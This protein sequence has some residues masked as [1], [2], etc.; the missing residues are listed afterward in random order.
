MRQNEITIA[1]GDML[2]FSS[3]AIRHEPRRVCDQTE[4]VLRRNG[5]RG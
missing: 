3:Y 2:I 1:R 4:A 5:W